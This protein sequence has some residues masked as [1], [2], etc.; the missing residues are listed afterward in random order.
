MYSIYCIEDVNGLKYIGRTRDKKGI[1]NR[2][3]NHRSDKNQSKGCS[4]QL[5][6]LDNCKITCIDTC[7]TNEESLKLEKHYM[8]SIDCVNK[9][10][11]NF[12]PKEYKKQYDQKNKEKNKSYRDKHK[13]N[14]REYDKKRREAMKLTSG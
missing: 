11:G 14:K 2:L 12:N 5:L 13:E 8:N 9:Q 1:I 7:E 6:D 10:K 3:Y 4:S